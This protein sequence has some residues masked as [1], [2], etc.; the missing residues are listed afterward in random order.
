MKAIEKIKSLKLPKSD[1][2]EEL[3][4]ISERAFDKL[5]NETKFLVRKDPNDK[6]VDYH[7]EVKVDGSC[8][9]CRFFVQLKSTQSK[10]PNRDGSIS[11]KIYT[12]N[13]NYLRFGGIPAYYVLYDSKTKRLFFR[14]VLDVFREV[15]RKSPNWELQKTHSVR[16]SRPLD[17]V[18]LN[19]IYDDAINQGL[20]RMEVLDR[21]SLAQVSLLVGNKVLIGDD[22]QVTDDS[23]IRN[24]ILEKGFGM[25]NRGEWKEVLE[26][27]RSGSGNVASPAGYML[28]VGIAYHYT[29]S[30][31]EAQAMFE[32][33]L[34]RK[35][36]LD[37]QLLGFLQYFEA[38]NNQALGRLTKEE[39]MQSISELEENT[40]VSLYARIQ[41]AKDDYLKAVSLGQNG[42]YEFKKAMQGIQDDPRSI[43]GIK[44]QVKLE[45]S[46]IEG[47]AINIEFA[48]EYLHLRAWE[49]YGGVNVDARQSLVF[50]FMRRHDS[51][52]N[53]IGNVIDET[54][55][56]DDF[57]GCC[58]AILLRG[59]VVY[60]FYASVPQ[61]PGIAEIISMDQE[62]VLRE[63]LLAVG[64]ALAY[65][66]SKGHVDN[67]CAALLLQYEIGHLL[68]DIEVVSA[69]KDELLQIKTEFRNK[70][71]TRKID[72]LLNNGTAHERWRELL[73]S[74]FDRESEALKRIYQQQREEC[75]EMDR[76]EKTWSNRDRGNHQI[77][78]FP[79]GQFAFP[80]G[81]EE[82]V[83]EIIGVKSDRV[84]NVFDSMF[85]MGIAPTANIYYSEIVEEGYRDGELANRGFDNWENLYR[86]RK[87]FFDRKFR[88]V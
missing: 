14:N 82:V 35:V 47:H 59:K 1:P 48:R 15:S 25:I 50:G 41:K 31:L 62:P 17:E 78:L 29:G 43:A 10:K 30:L 55:S 4:T 83:Y 11:Q 20:M 45:A 67:R 24:E 57:F 72:W 52:W 23:G 32:R 60:E 39:F 56:V 58:T 3:M 7:I 70:E 33:A 73:E 21:I 71:R 42:P 53:D 87:A 37:G 79:M 51:W 76:I 26:L 44:L 68:D 8:T 9:N 69:A 38:V 64:S 49:E 75:E 19:E 6:G 81:E 18:A 34:L 84:R 22:L 40:A 80:K 88:R 12:T 85:G 77:Q 27:H 46:A 16:M 5:L 13:I 54:R 74:T 36:E 61:L 65:F 63:Q 86:V 2:N 66:K 28:I